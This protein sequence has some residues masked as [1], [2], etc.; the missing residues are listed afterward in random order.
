LARAALYGPAGNFYLPRPAFEQLACPR[1]SER[2]RMV[3]ELATVSAM[4]W[5]CA[6][7]EANRERLAL[8][9]L[10][11]AGY[12]IYAPKIAVATPK[13]RRTTLLFPSYVFVQIVSGW[14]NARW[15]AGVV[16][17]LLDGGSEPA[18]VPDRIISELRGLER[19]G[20]V[21]VMLRRRKAGTFT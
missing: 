3:S 7:V 12:T 9:C 21:Q 15:S 5:G 13:A 11:L 6:Q 4:Y 14:W 19:D 20:L 16:R 8:H 17:L 18:H 2:L 1:I 10:G